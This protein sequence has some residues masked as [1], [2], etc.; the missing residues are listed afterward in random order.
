ML[1]KCQLATRKSHVAGSLSTNTSLRSTG[2]TRSHVAGMKTVILNAHSAAAEH[3]R[4]SMMQPSTLNA[5][6]LLCRI[7]QIGKTTL[8]NPCMNICKAE[9]QLGTVS[10]SGQCLFELDGVKSLRSQSRP[11]A[12][13]QT[14]FSATARGACGGVA[15]RARVRN[16]RSTLMI[17]AWFYAR[18]QSWISTLLTK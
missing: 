18:Q 16:V 1:Q 9:R 7:C 14:A 4:S 10:E 5:F 3:C 13:Y 15:K 2:Q 6:S 17:V 11:Y 8:G 12:A